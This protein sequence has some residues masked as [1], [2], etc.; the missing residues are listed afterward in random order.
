[1]FVLRAKC[2]LSTPAPRCRWWPGRSRRG[3]LAG[4]D[5]PT[6]V[7][8]KR[9]LDGGGSVVRLPTRRASRASSAPGSRRRHRLP[10]LDPAAWRRLE[11]LSGVAHHH[12][13]TVEQ[14]VPQMLN[15]ELIGGVDF[16]QGLLSRPGGRRTQPVPRHRQA[17]QLPVRDRRNRLPGSGG[18]RCRRRSIAAVRPGRQRGARAGGCGSVALVEV[19]LAS[20]AAGQLRLRCAGRPAAAAVADALPVPIGPSRPVGVATLWQRQAHRLVHD[21]GLDELAGRGASNPARR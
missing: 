19:K 14:F 16:P 11:V 18:L 9:D 7:G 13:P 15:Y 20:V 3:A 5:A 21:A 12:P 17:P 1:M 6:A 2:T 4:A 10:A 8:G